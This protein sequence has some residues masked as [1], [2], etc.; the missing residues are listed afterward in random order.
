MTFFREPQ[1]IIQLKNKKKRYHV[2]STTVPEL[3][4]R[5]YLSKLSKNNLRIIFVKSYLFVTNC[6]FVVLMF[7]KTNQMLK[8]FQKWHILRF[9]VNLMKLKRALTVKKTKWIACLSESKYSKAG[10]KST[11]LTFVTWLTS[12][13]PWLEIFV[14]YWSHCHLGLLISQFRVNKCQPYLTN[15]KQLA[16]S[17]LQCFQL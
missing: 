11:M 15:K 1:C 10:W 8:Y 12:R 17:A 6:F 4:V 9:E 3:S 2:A 13:Q 5:A 7:R 14:S 16:Y